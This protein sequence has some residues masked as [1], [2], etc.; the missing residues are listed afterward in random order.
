[1]SPISTSGKVVLSKPTGYK[2]KLANTS[3]DADPYFSS[4]SLLLD[5]TD[6]LDKSLIQKR[7]L[8]MVTLKS[9]PPKASGTGQAWRLM[10]RVI[11]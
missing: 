6:L 7:S 10:V 1:M 2:I 9:V 3:Q 11:I 8:S 5:G 4:V